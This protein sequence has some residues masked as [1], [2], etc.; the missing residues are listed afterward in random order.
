M[1][2]IKAYIRHDKVE[3]VV[4]K[5]EEAGIK[6][7]TIL[8][9]NALAEWADPEA[10]SFSVE[11]VEKYS[12]IVKIELICQDKEADNIASVIQRFANTGKRGDG[13]IFVAPIER[14]IRIKNGEEAI[15]PES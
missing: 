10:F 6:G 9:A 12:K 5:L 4:E 1:K 3:K 13:W 7:M 14:A 11:Y 2:E 15:N 8:D